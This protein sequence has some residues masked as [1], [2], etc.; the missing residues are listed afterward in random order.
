MSIDLRLG[1]YK[2]VLAD[3][4]C[5]AVICDP[6]Y[7]KRTHSGRR[8]GSEIRQ[9]EINYQHITEQDA[10]EF[11]EFWSKRCRWW[12][13]IFCDHVSRRWHHDSWESVGWYVFGPVRWVKNNAPPRMSGDGPCVSTEDILVARQKRRLPPERSGSR[14]GHYLT[15]GAGLS[16][17]AGKEYP[18]AK[19]L[20]VMN[21]IIRDYSKPGDTICDPCAGGGTTLLAAASQGRKAIGAEMDPETY[22]KAKERIEAGYTEDMFVA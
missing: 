12:V 8:T 1:D 22:Q 5:D 17:M 19:P 6:P 20:S 16:C 2:D 18:G 11:S 15:N 7:S 3:V 9:S 10:L 13:L 14:R 21:A 4:E